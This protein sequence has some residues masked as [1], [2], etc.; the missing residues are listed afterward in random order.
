MPVRVQISGVEN[1]AK[2]YTV[3]LIDPKS[4]A[5]LAAKGKTRGMP[6]FFSKDLSL[7]KTAVLTPGD[8]VLMITNS[9]NI[10]RTMVVHAKV[11]L[12]VSDDG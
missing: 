11:T 4:A 10:M 2:G 3:M 8:Y 1:T 9:E 5:E 12:N 7:K 6:E